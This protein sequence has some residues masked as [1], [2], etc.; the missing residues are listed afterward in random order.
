MARLGI[1][2]PHEAKSVAIYCN[3]TCHASARARAAKGQEPGPVQKKAT[4]ADNPNH[5]ENF[6]RLV[7]RQRG[8]LHDCHRLA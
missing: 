7:T 5:G 6:I 4:E 8:S 1:L 3:M 2:A